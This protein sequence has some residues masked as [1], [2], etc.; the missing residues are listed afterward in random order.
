[1]LSM[2]PATNVVAASTVLQLEPFTHKDYKE[3]YV[4]DAEFKDVYQECE[5]G[6]TSEF[7]SDFH[8]QNGL[9]YRMGRLCIPQEDTRI[10]L[11]REAHILKVAGHFGA[12]Q[13]V[14]NLQAYVCWPK[15]QNDVAKCIV[16]CKLCCTSKPTV[17]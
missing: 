5:Q 11:I 7:S 9:L 2:P 14:S 12:S 3:L 1:M 10:C 16:D 17:S 13:I 8:L 6:G 15:L 4:E